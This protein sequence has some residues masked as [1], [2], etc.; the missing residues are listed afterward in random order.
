MTL[1]TTSLLHLGSTTY[2]L[3]LAGLDTLSRNHFLLSPENYVTYW[4]PQPHAI[5][6]LAN[7][8]SANQPSANQPL[9]NQPQPSLQLAPRDQISII[10]Q[11]NPAQPHDPP[12]LLFNSVGPEAE[13]HQRTFNFLPLPTPRPIFSFLRPKPKPQVILSQQ[14]GPLVSP[15]LNVALK[16]LL[17]STPQPHPLPSLHLVRLKL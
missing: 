15:P 1:G 2:H 16:P 5:Q 4:Q 12:I 3:F 11:N 14:P 13:H 6:L 10:Q 17:Q 9:A 7:Q 8:P